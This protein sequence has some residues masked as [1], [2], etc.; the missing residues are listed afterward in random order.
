MDDIQNQL[1]SMYCACKELE[2]RGRD[3][4][5]LLLLSGEETG[6]WGAKAF[7]RTGFR[8]PYLVIGEP[9]E[10]QPANAAKGTTGYALT[11]TG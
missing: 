1:F 5:A 6:S 11:F 7:D 8:A 2:A 10:N 3:G 9:T 4:F